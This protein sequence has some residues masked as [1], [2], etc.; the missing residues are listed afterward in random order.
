MS[1]PLATS[2]VFS[3]LGLALATLLIGAAATVSPAHA[4]AP[5]A[6]VELVQPGDADMSCAALTAEI[7]QL[8][9]GRA[10]AASRAA[11]GRKVFGFAS[12]AFQV[13]APMMTG[14]LI[15]G[16]GGL[17]GGG[18]MTSI[19]GQAASSAV[20]QGVMQASVRGAPAAPAADANDTSIEAQRIQRLTAMLQTKGC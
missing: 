12:T 1:R 9:A 20:Q 2:R 11:A 10:K 13:A 18:M 6:R 3:P 17:G 15:G 14:G 5:A 16:F 8:A 7:N 19:L 4:A